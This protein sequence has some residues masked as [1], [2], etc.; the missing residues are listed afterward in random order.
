MDLDVL[1]ADA[2]VV[3][4]TGAPWFRADVGIADGRIAVVGRVDAHATR[5]IDA[6]DR[7]V[8]PGWIDIHTHSDFGVI[9]DPPAGCAVRQGSTTHVIG[10]CGVSAAPIAPE[11]RELHAKQLGD[12]GHPLPDEWATYSGYLEAIDR[13]GVGVNVAPLVG[14]GTIRL[15]VLGME[16]RRPTD[17]ELDRMRGHVDEAMHAGCFG[18]STGLVY[19]PGCFGDTDEVIALAEVVARHGGMYASHIRGERETILDAVAE[20]IAIGER[21]GCRT[22]ISHNCPKYGGWQLQDE[23]IALWEGARA[24]GLDV[25]VDNDLHTDFGPSLGEALPQWTFRLTTDELVTLLRDPQ[26]RTS[27][28]DETQADRRPAFGPA[29]LLVHEAFDRIFVLRSPTRPDHDGRTIA[30]IATMR[31]VDPWD[32]FF[33]QIIDDRNETMAV[34]DYIDE[35]AI[36]RMLRHPLV[37]VCSDGWV[38]PPD[39]RAGNGEPAPYMPC[40]YGEYPG[41]IE[42]YVVNAPVLTLEEAVR[43]STSMPAT[44]IGLPDRGLIKPGFA[45]DLIVFEPERVRDLAT[46]PWPHDRGFPTYPHEYPDGIDWVFVNGTVAVEDG[47]FLSTLGGHV[48]R[49]RGLR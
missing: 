25:T 28:R 17:D 30:E 36:R 23:V 35:A 13:R 29:G 22:Q 24:R 15:A 42:R 37:M 2:R 12:Y 33:D 48:L 6:A 19:P 39:A 46:D 9:A 5:T 49:A 11:R 26:Q 47:E 34:F 10:N 4:G 8:A 44:K 20:C 32:A 3:D 16:E 27:I 21:S 1:I 18:M 38:I 40:S 43:K 45:A 31:G 7:V 14:H 41:L